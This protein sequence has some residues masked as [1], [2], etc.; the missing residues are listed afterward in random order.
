MSA[1]IVSDETISVIAKGLVEYGIET[2][3][4]E[5]SDAQIIIANLRY[6]PFGQWLLDQNY[7]SVNYRYDEDTKAPEFE[8]KEIEADEGTLLGCI[9]CYEYQAC[10]TPNYDKSEIHSCLSQL[11]EEM[12]E[13]LIKQKGQ[14]IEWGI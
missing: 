5:L 2:R 1:Y 9:K 12:L 13:R 6:K 4:V 8:Y 3:E 11:K 10:E 14:K 7:K